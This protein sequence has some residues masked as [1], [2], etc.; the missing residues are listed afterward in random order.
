MSVVCEMLFTSIGCKTK[1]SNDA[2]D[3]ITDV[4]IEDMIVSKVELIRSD[5]KSVNVMSLS[6][7]LEVTLKKGRTNDIHKVHNPHRLVLL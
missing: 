6:E 7:P 4:E 2:D 5:N 1:L 3:K